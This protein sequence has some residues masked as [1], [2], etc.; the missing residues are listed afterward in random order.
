MRIGEMVRR[1]GV[2][3]RLLRYYEE[4]GLLAPTRLP[5]GYRVYTDADVDTVRRVRALLA[6]GLPTTTIAQVLP[7]IRDD[8]TTLAPVCSDLVA[9]LRRERDRITDAIKELE[10]SRGMLDAVI[11]A[12]PSDID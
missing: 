10:T 12:G 3:E 2:S 5:S 8:G 11:A 6:A 7:C 1:T 9:Q 4:Q